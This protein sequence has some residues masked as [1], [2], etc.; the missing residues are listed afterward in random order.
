MK[1]CRRCGH[2]LPDQLMQCDRQECGGA[3]LVPFDWGRFGLV[4]LGEQ[5]PVAADQSHLTVVQA[6]APMTVT[7]PALGAFPIPYPGFSAVAMFGGCGAVAPMRLSGATA[8]TASLGRFG[9]FGDSLPPFGGATGP[10]EDQLRALR[11]QVQTAHAELDLLYQREARR[12]IYD[13]IEGQ[14][15]QVRAARRQEDFF[16]FHDHVRRLMHDMGAISDVRE[17]LRNALRRLAVDVV[18]WLEQPGYRPG[19]D[20]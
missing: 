17:E 14:L 7:V 16:G 4:E 2:T 12:G 10:L 8:A 6:P 9:P 18:L 1:L 11:T 3:D 19:E 20:G 15:V 13:A 5:A